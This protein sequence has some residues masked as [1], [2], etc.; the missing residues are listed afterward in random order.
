[1][2][3]PRTRSAK[4][5]KGAG[6]HMRAPVEIEQAV[7]VR[8]GFLDARQLRYEQSEVHDDSSFRS[9]RV[10]RGCVEPHAASAARRNGACGK[11]GMN[12]HRRE[13]LAH[14][15]GPSRRTH[16]RRRRSSKCGCAGETAEKRERRAPPAGWHDGGFKI[17]E[18]DVVPDQAE[19][20]IEGLLL[21]LSKAVG[22]ICED[23]GIVLI[24][25]RAR[26]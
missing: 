26:Q 18:R 21:Q 16:A 9:A 1:M 6:N 13:R 2:S 15:S 20:L 10:T 23:F 11:R 7:V 14:D 4:R 25:F 3:E 24:A 19:T 8:A 17:S 22:P 12:E 5:S